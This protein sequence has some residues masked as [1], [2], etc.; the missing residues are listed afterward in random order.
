MI[1]TGFMGSG[2]T[3][4]GRRV[5][6]LLG[7]EFIDLDHYIVESEGRTIPSIFESD[8][9]SGFRAIEKASLKKIINSTDAVISTGGGIITYEESR[10]L[11][12]DNEHHTVY[13][14]SA[15]FDLLYGR[16]K[17]DENRPMLK[18][19]YEAVRVLYESRVPLY[20]ESCHYTVDA[21][22]SAEETAGILLALE[23]TGGK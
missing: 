15:P 12:K 14:L 1:L 6:E 18:Q 21:A 7:R 2:K 16:I 17:D 8:G 22:L 9:E 4:V 3:T 19:G 20:E 11:L 10:A 5:A 13:Y 23:N